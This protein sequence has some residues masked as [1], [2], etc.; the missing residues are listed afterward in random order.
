MIL[1]KTNFLTRTSSE[2]DV[3][4]LQ[5]LTSP[6]RNTSTWCLANVTSRI[7][8]PHSAT[9]EPPAYLSASTEVGRLRGTLDKEFQRTELPQQPDV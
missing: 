7:Y 6:E 4:E 2:Y 5:L 9:M 1:E 8:L 3:E